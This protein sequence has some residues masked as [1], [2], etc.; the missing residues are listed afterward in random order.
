MVAI[1]A[2][3]S[4]DVKKAV[5][6][7]SGNVPEIAAR[8]ILEEIPEVGAVFFDITPKPPATVEYE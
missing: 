4:I 6:N 2:I 5:P 1:R 7:F 8:R 3:D